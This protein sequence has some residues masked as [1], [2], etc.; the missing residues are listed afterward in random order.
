[1]LNGSLEIFIH[2]ESM[3]IYYYNFNNPNQQSSVDIQ[4]VS[5]FLAAS[6]LFFNELGIGGQDRTFRILR[7]DTELRMSLGNKIHAT[8]LIRGL[9]DLDLKAYYEL[10]VMTRAII[11]RFENVYMQE[12]EDFILRGRFNFDGIDK[13]IKDEVLKMKAHMFSS[14]LMH[15]LGIAI[16][17]NVKKSEAKE[18]LISL[19][20]IYAD[21]P[22]NYD[23]IRKHHDVI[24]NQIRDYQKEHITFK[25]IIKKVNK[26]S[27]NIWKL[28]RI[29]LIP[30]FE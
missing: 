22:L 16:N 18:L 27:A 11:N 10:D 17:R 20:S 26:E 23:K 12:I 1:M 24:W 6:S 8:L 9:E 7:G 14:Y 2:Y 15:I 3:S 28:F 13:F 30:V 21:L 25:N 5:G 29:P 19:N 4:L